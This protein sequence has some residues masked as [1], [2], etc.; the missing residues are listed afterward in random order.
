MGVEDMAAPYGASGKRLAENEPIAG[1]EDD[2]AR[3][4]EPGEARS[5]GLESL[6]AIKEDVGHDFRGEGMEVDAGT[7]LEDWGVGEERNCGIDHVGWCELAGKDERLASGDF[8]G[9]DAGEIHSDPGA[10]LSEFFGLAVGLQSADANAARAGLDVQ[11]LADADFAAEEGPRNHGTEAL[12]YESAVDGEAHGAG[13]LD[14]ARVESKAGES[15]AD[16]LEACSGM[17]AGGEDCMR[18]RIEES[19]CEKGSYLVAYFSK[20]G[21]RD[22]LGFGYDS[23]T[24]GDPEQLA[25]G[26]VF[27]CLRHDALV[28]SDDEHDG[29][30]ASS[31]GEH[32]A[33]EECVA[34][35][36]NETDAKSRALRRDHIE[37]SEAEVDGD[38]AAFF[39]GEAVGVDAGESADER[40]LA[41]VDV[42]GGS[43]DDGWDEVH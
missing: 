28:G 29:G 38:A 19:V 7:M 43:D 17:G 6:V 14:A 4:S 35:D 15:G 30:D 22:E 5:I 34:G 33:D 12:L 18:V 20:L 13:A 42:P 3:E 8:S 25:D 9:V 41:V 24:A 16:G 36:I 40:G 23:E 32:V 1:S 39:F 11:G 26:E 21:I 27:A 37:G 10:R 2:G 31:A